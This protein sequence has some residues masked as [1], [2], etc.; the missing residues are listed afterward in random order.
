MQILVVDDKQAILNSLEKLLSSQG[1]FVD[2]AI[3][4]LAASEKLQNKHYD[5]LIIDHLMPIMNGIQL[6]KHVRQSAVFANTPIIFMTTQGHSAVK[7]LCNIDLF[8]AVIDKP[9]DEQN[10]VKLINKLLSPNTL[11]Q[12]L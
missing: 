9:I 6:T 4:G 7:S 11:Y 1:Y 2:S 8:T 12:L 10:L 3:H 5:L